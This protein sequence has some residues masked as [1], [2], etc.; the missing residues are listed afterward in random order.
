MKK[1]L[2]YSAV[3]IFAALGTYICIDAKGRL[4][5]EQNRDSANYAMAADAPL[6][7]ANKVK[8]S[9]ILV[10]TQAEAQNLKIRIDKGENF[11]TLAKKYSSCP[12]RES[13]GDLGYF[14]RG[15][16]VQEFET[17]A[18]KAPVGV[19]TE[20]VKTQFGWHL[21]KVYDRK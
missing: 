14:T 10:G 18:F 6:K 9:H 5:T 7:E 11:E 16:M 12:S 20:P 8:A 3:F 15:Q 17:A 4:M 21:I 2:I 13:G 1:M 19:V